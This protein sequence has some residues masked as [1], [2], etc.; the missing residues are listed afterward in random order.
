MQTRLAIAAILVVL[1]TL[2]GPEVQ[3]DA[4]ITVTFRL[5]LEGRVPETEGFSLLTRVT[6][7]GEWP[8]GPMPT[9]HCGPASPGSVTGRPCEAGVTYTMAE[10]RVPAG[11]TVHYRYDRQTLGGEGEV[12]KEETRTFDADALVEEHYTFREE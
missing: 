1:G 3:R 6:Q 7:A 11:A 12:F 10:L 5:V 4:D 8:S 2:C 9:P